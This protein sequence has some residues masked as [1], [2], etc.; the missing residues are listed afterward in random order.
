MMQETKDFQGIRR[1]NDEIIG[2]SKLNIVCF[3]GFI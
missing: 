1:K 2:N 3:G